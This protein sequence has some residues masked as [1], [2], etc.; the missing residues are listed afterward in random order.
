MTNF[1]HRTAGLVLTLLPVGLLS[2]SA[3]P[4]GPESI[5]QLGYA[6]LAWSKVENAFQPIP[7][8]G[9]GPVMSD[10]A[11]ASLGSP[12]H[13]VRIADLNNP[14]LKPWVIKS[15]RKQNALA[16]AGKG[17][18]EA[19]ANCQPGG[20]PGFLVMGALNPM[21]IIQGPRE[22]VMINEGG[23][24]VR[25]IYLNVPHS[26]HP[27]PSPNGESVG[28]YEGDTLVVDTIGL[29]ANTYIDNYR[30]PHTT[31]EHVVERFRVIDDQPGARSPVHIT[32]MVD[33]GKALQID[34]HVEDPGAFNMPWNARQIYRLGIPLES[35]HG[36]LLEAICSE[37]NPSYI[38][39]GSVLAIP[40]A[41]RPDF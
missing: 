35:L 6:Y 2:A 29:S 18:Y 27:K 1:L 23:P 41:M 7:G 26:P 40:V 36:Q 16:A 5:P 17:A 25:H 13:P 3:A 19:Q 14:I 32:G 4:A 24:H 34:I 12:A 39:S 15:M 10:E 21:Y 9:P 20:V 38:D 37:N 8:A 33:K 28:H 31:Q 22:I 30:T 11:H